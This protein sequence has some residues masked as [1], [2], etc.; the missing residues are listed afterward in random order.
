ME[1]ARRVARNALYRTASLMVGSVSGL[2]LTVFLARILKPEQFGMY[3]LALSIAMLAIA[4][5]N[6]GI[7]GAVVRYTAYHIGR[8]NLEKVRGHFRY[9]L[10]FKLILAFAVSVILTLLSSLLAYFFGDEKLILPFV[11][12]GVVVFFASFTNFLNAFFIGLQ[13]FRYS[14][15]RQITY[16][17]SRWIFILPLSILFLAFGVMTGYSLAFLTAGISLLVILLK[18]YKNLVFGRAERIDEKVISFIGFTT[19]A[20]ISGTIYAYIDCIMIGWLLTPTDVGYY[21]AA[22]T[23]VFAVIGF[24][25]MADVLL[26]VFTQLER[27]DLNKAVS[28]IVRYTSAIAFPAALGLAF[29]SKDIINVVYGVDY[30]EASYPFFILSFV[31]IPASFNYLFTI[32]SAKE[33]PKYSAYIVSISMLLNIVLNYILI[34]LMGIVGAALATLISR[35]FAIALGMYFLY[36][37]FSLNISIDAYIKPSI[38]SPLMLFLLMLLPAPK[39][40]IVGVI[41]VLVAIIFYFTLLFSLKGLSMEDFKYFANLFRS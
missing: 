5:A 1:I 40:L 37:V 15:L 11:F 32:F 23:I 14:F 21:K 4:L 3:S 18:K 22:F 12:A 8:K 13:E 19:I 20:G 26:P 39:S 6:L 41:D 2:F 10:K 28:R 17:L 25:T 24:L 29:L 30:L 16:E 35:V 38:C 34:Q 31:L 7:D 9:F 33:V 27:G 36:K